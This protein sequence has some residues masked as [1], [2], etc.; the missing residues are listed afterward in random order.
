MFYVD[1]LSTDFQIVFNLG[2][3]LLAKR[4]KK[5]VK[6]ENKLMAVK[7]NIVFCHPANQLHFLYPIIKLINILK[8]KLI[9]LFEVVQNKTIKSF[10]F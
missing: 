10:I 3:L 8:C 7:F 5:T 4:K 9:I 2:Y 6:E 1:F